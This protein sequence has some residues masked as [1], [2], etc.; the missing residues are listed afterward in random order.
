MSYLPFVLCLCLSLPAAASAAST[1]TQLPAA[2]QRA[3]SAVVSIRTHVPANSPSV[4]TLGP[5]RRGSGVIIDTAGYIVTV[6]YILVDA[7]FIEVGLSDGRTL[8]ARLVGLDLEQGFGLIQLDGGGPWPAAPLGDS[9]RVTIG[10]ATGTLG[11]GDDDSLTV[12]PGSIHD[13]R[14]FAGYW[15]YV[16]DRAFIVRPPNPAFGGS[17]VVNAAGEVIGIASLQLGRPPAENLAIPIAGF[18]QVKDELIA[19]GR[20]TSRKVR[21]WLGLY[22]VQTDRGVVVIGASPVG[23][24]A[25]ADFQ[26]G[27]VILRVNGDKI[28]GQEDFYRKL[29]RADVTQEVRL[30]V[31]RDT[32][33]V[34]ITVKPIN[35]YDLLAPRGK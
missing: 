27:D 34:V 1:P 18:L 23:P 12:T 24:A 32:T 5:L 33:F 2:W 28:D 15:E 7:D 3:L 25:E 30:V 14:S 9:A 20:V 17:P 10:D 13:I 8:P 22:T 31:L 35:R 19:A 16:L 29:W 4:L 21:P 6:G 26:R 11:M